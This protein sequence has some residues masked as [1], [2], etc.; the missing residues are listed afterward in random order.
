[1]WRRKRLV[2]I[3]SDKNALT[4]FCIGLVVIAAV[5]GLVGEIAAG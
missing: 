1:M 4:W 5:A 3:L 2:I